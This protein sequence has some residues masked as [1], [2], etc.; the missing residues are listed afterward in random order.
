MSLKI[1]FLLSL[2]ISSVSLMAQKHVGGYGKGFVGLTFNGFPG[3]ENRLSDNQLF[4]SQAQVPH[5]GSVVGGGG[6]GFRGKGWVVGTGGFRARGFA[7]E[8][9]KGR[10]EAELS[11]FT[12]QTGYVVA[13]LGKHILFP[14]LGLGRGTSWLNLINRSGH[15]MIIDENHRIDNDE[16]H[17]YY[18]KSFTADLGFSFMRLRYDP[19]HDHGGF[20]MGIDAGMV[21]HFPQTKWKYEVTHD[22]VN[23]LPAGMPYRFYVRFF[24]GG[25]FRKPVLN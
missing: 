3:L 1:F 10:I 24:V 18:L 14:Y 22:V 15:P 17:R 2:I 21:I 23:G 13:D 20:T 6:F 12:I 11:M 19:T 16:A 4:G 9:D 25:I 8:S 7:Y 5:F